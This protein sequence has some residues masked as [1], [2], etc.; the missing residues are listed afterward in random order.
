MKKQ[1]SSMLAIA[2]LVAGLSPAV[3][4]A[5]A[6]YP[7]KP[8]TIIVPYAPGGTTDVVGRALADS[9]SRQLGQTV[10][11]ENKP[12]AA[13][14][15]G[16]ID[17]MGT[18]PDGYRLTMAPVGIF[19]QPYLQQTR[20]D[21]IRDLTY[22]ATFLTYDFAITVK[23][24][25]PYKTIQD[26]VEAARKEPGSIDY[27]STG[28]F[29]GNHVALAMLGKAAGV[30][31]THVPYKGDSDAT[32]ALL[33]GHVKAAVITNSIL[34]HVR[35]GTVRV[36]ATS[37][38]ERNPAFENVPTMKE[39]GYDVL[40]PSPLGLAGPAGLPAPIVEKLDQAVKAALQDPDVKRVVDNFGVRT[41]YMD[42]KAYAD[43]AR[44]TFAAEKDIVTNLDLENN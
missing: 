5:Q 3:A 14:A 2:G 29:T 17:M 11:I 31:F 33:G 26:L 19:R 36:L 16:V 7:N 30:K 8:I 20:Y 40:V 4:T 25:A 9:L 27:S 6:D 22:I 23:A 37:D 32:S 13:G 42:H 38:S 1:I 41:V 12:G 35:A 44:Q 24:D 43:F 15:M 18:K 10:V 39:L 34:S 21:P 28:R